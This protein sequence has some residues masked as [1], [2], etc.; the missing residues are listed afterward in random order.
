MLLKFTVKAVKG[1]EIKQIEALQKKLSDGKRLNT[2]VGMGFVRSLRNHFRKQNRRPNKRGWRKQGVW[3]K[4]A[5]DTTF[6]GADATSATVSIRNPIIKTKIFGARI[7]P[8]GGK[9][10][11]AIPAIEARYGIMP[12]SLEPGELTF[13]K[14][15][16]GGI[17]GKIKADGTMTVHYWLVRSAN[18]PSDADALPKPETVAEDAKIAISKYIGRKS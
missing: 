3:N 14:T 6:A 9:K 17:L 15:R 2:A 4:I 8:K 11:L 18:I 5:A 1:A 10:F 7:K 13:R 12:S 16:K